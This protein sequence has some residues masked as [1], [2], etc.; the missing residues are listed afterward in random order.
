[1]IVLL[2][3]ALRGVTLLFL[4]GLVLLLALLHWAGEHVSL[5]SILLFIPP[6]LLLLPMSVLAPACLLLGLW[7][8]C[9]AQ[10]A[11]AA[12]LL[13]GYMTY[14][15]GP[16]A[17][18]QPP[19]L[20]VVTHNAGEDNRP[21]FAAFLAAEHPDVV[22]LQDAANR[23]AEIVRAHPDWH[24]ASLGEFVCLTRFP[25]LSSRLTVLPSWRRGPVLA[26]FEVLFREQKVV[27]YSVH[28]PTPRHELQGFLSH[29]PWRGL[30]GYRNWLAE[31]LLLGRAVA[32]VLASETGP[33][34]VG[35]DFNMPD[36]GWLYHRFTPF[37]T[38]VFATA[39]HGRGVT[40][41]GYSHN[42]LTRGPWLRLDYLWAGKGWQPLTCHPSSG[43]LS[44]HR[45]VVARF[46]FAPTGK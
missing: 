35:G 5:L 31:R 2:R 27:F 45:A 21:E 26:R 3:V 7:R 32:E 41:P 46:A 28:F 6:Q 34:I 17:P 1:M 9:A 22:L 12:L 37:L 24:A 11:V 36:H 16:A 4:A 19:D 25:I 20:T 10:L 33:M 38:D 43:S 44:Q 30:I 29:R 40:F 8:L 15:T 39:G 18:S 23:A 42:W 13:F 14:A